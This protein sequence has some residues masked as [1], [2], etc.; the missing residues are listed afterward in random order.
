MINEVELVADTN[1]AVGE[2]PVWHPETQQVF[3][4]D[5]TEGIIHVYSPSTSDCRVFSEGPVVGGMVLNEDGNLLLF[6]DGRVSLL[7]LDGKQQELAAEIDPENDRFNDAI[8]DP[9]GRVFVGTMGANGKL[10]RID[11]DGS[12]TEIMDGLSVPNGKGF[13]SDLKQM[14]FI[15]SDPH[16]IYV[17]HYGQETGNLSNWRVL[18]TLSQ[19]EGFPDGM[20]MDADGYIWTA[21]WCGGRLARFAP[22]GHLD[23]EIHLPVR[24]PSAVTFGGPDLNELYITTAASDLADWMGP[25]DYDK[26]LPRGGGLYRLRIEGIRGVAP[27]RSRIHFS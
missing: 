6:Q 17:F 15:D 22:D 3:F 14:Y 2:T 16:K 18:A 19:D 12:V 25:S 5:L 1:C 23:C 20:T 7:T 13:S 24:Q 9:K 27:F 4:L 11:L 26:A 10:L 8:V 21:L